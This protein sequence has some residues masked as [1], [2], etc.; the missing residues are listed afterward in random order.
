M[1]YGRISFTFQKIIY[2]SLKDKLSK[3][4]SLS[5]QAEIVLIRKVGD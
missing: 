2:Y 5:L 1:I 3:L 4:D